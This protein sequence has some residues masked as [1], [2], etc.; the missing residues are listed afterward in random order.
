MCARKY[1]DISTPVDVGCPWPPA[2]GLVAGGAVVGPA[3]H[4]TLLRWVILQHLA[5]GSVPPVLN[6]GA[7]DGLGRS[8]GGGWA[9]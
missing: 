3:H 6:G 5:V 4:D 2:A 9:E 8:R 1:A 7:V